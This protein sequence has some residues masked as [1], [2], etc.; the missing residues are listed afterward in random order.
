MDGIPEADNDD[1]TFNYPPELV[2]YLWTFKESVKASF[3]WSP[4]P[5]AGGLLDQPDGL[6]DDLFLLDWLHDFLTWQEK[7]RRGDK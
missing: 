7:K 3:G 1:W 2:W 4:L 5:V 6:L